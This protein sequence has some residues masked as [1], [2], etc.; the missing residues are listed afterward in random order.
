MGCLKREP[1][2][3]PRHDS[4]PRDNHSIISIRKKK[5]NQ[6]I[7]ICRPPLVHSKTFSQGGG[8]GAR[9]GARGTPNGGPGGEGPGGGLGAEPPA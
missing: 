8:R 4:G 1:R 5:S 2:S 7:N 9:V 6:K 3:Y